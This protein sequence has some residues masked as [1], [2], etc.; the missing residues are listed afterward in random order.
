MKTYLRPYLAC[1]HKVVAK[2]GESEEQVIERWNKKH[3][4]HKKRAKENT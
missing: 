4:S 1:T 3:G 2:L